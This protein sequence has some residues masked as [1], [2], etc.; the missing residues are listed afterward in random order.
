MKYRV[1][2]Y[3]IVRVPFEIEADSEL[4]ALKKADEVDLAEELAKGWRGEFADDIDGYL[5]DELGDDGFPVR[6]S[7]YDKHHIRKE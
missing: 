3:A 7:N 1:H 6:S 5:V 2:V 4:E